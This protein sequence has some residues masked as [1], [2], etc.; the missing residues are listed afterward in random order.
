MVNHSF[1]LSLFALIGLS[2]LAYAATPVAVWDGN[3]NSLTCGNYTIDLQGNT[4]VTTTTTEGEAVITNALSITDDNLGVL[5]KKNSGSYDVITALVRCEGVDLTSSSDQA[6]FVANSPNDANNPVGVRLTASNTAVKGIWQNGKWDSVTGSA[7]TNTYTTLAFKYNRTDGTGKGTYLYA[8]TTNAEGVAS[9]SAIYSASELKRSAYYPNGVA[10][11]GLNT[12]SISELTAAKGMKISAIAIFEGDLSEAEMSSYKFLDDWLVATNVSGE[13]EWDKMTCSQ[14]WAEG[15]ATSN[16]VITLTGD[17]TI[18]LP[19]NFSANTIIF[20][21]NYNVT[22]KEASG[23]KTMSPISSLLGGK[24][25]T[26]EIPN[27]FSSTSTTFPAGITYRVCSGSSVSIGGDRKLSGELIVETNAT[28]TALSNDVPNYDNGFTLRVYGTLAHDNNRWTYKAGTLH[29]YGGCSVTG[30]GDN[31]GAVD[32]WN[33]IY[34]H[35]GDG[36]SDD[37]TTIKIDAPVRYSTSSATIN[38]DEGVTVTLAQAGKSGNDTSLLTKDGAGTLVFGAAQ[39]PLNGTVKVTAGT[40]VFDCESAISGKVNLASGTT[41]KV[42]KGTYNLSS[43]TLNGSVVVT[44]GTVTVPSTMAGTAKEETDGTIKVAVT[45]KEWADGV[46]IAS[47]KVTLRS[48]HTNLTFVYDGV[49]VEGTGMTLGNLLMDFVLPGT[50]TSQVFSYIYHPS[51]TDDNKWETTSNWK[52]NLRELKQSDGTIVTNYI[53]YTKS[54]AP[55]L[56]ESG[57]WAPILFDGVKVTASVVEGWEPQFGFYNHAD[58]TINTISKFQGDSQFIAVDE[59]SSLTIEALGS[60]SWD[61]TMNFYVAAPSGIVFS[62]T[63]DKKTSI[64]YYLGDKGSVAY[65]QGFSGT[66]TIKSVPIDLGDSTQYGRT[67]MKKYLIYG[68][69]TVTT[70]G[71]TVTG[72]TLAKTTAVAKTDEV[73]TYHFGSDETGLYI[74]WVAYASGATLT[75]STLSYPLPV[76]GTTQEF[77]YVYHP[78]GTDNKTWAT[79]TNWKTVQIVKDDTDS[80]ISTNYIAYTNSNAPGLSGS[81]TWDPILLDGVTV[82]A[83]QLEGWNARYGLYNGANVTVETQEKFQQD[84]ERTI[85]IF[86]AVDETSRFTV[87]AWG[88]SP[89]TGTIDFYVAA[90]SGIVFNVEYRKGD[91]VNYYIG[92]SGSV[93]YAKNVTAG[94][95]TLK[96]ATIELGDATLTGRQV[97]KKYLVI[98]SG[99]LTTSG[100]TVEGGTL[101]SSAVA[102]TDA[103]GTYY[104]GQDATG[105]Y[106]E[107]VAYAEKADGIF[108]TDTSG[109]IYEITGAFTKDANGAWVLDRAK[110]V[111]IT[112]SSGEETIFVIP[113]LATIEDDE[114]VGLVPFVLVESKPV[115]GVRTIPGLTYGLY[116]ATEL[117]A[118]WTNVKEEKANGRRVKF[119]DET[120]PDGKAFYQIRVRYVE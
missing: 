60:D 51:D 15:V 115:L 75:K 77:S 102:V 41:L 69:G 20:D 97:L 24:S 84:E 73:G 72:G 58:V 59:T 96:R 17:A 111:T 4:P 39:S 70:D 7:L 85:P 82:T 13:V 53:N 14:K 116:R 89:S 119:E 10:I 86:I 3:F 61:R 42:T 80:T 49:E 32:L 34:A 9:C 88:D 63:Y 48:D 45:A 40:L 5:V 90:P 21:G 81:G 112:D 93:Y 12:G 107:W 95:H 44:N 19:E 118:T 101:K 35:K 26:R 68:S 105:W 62:A 38:V 1:V 31:D 117:N 30:A 109:T 91:I 29:L 23:A 55:G 50:T 8:V 87:N 74:E 98:G 113:E 71:A 114:A 18:T 56:K 11:G 22:F 27:G 36:T 83:A 99:T 54:I 76:T 16:A 79:V 43:H 78:A 92:G 67:V 104:I 64:N 120:P 100:A 94:T 47:D 37:A 33:V 25:I 2:P 28:L 46:T 57:V 108:F 52:T 6:L 106:I 110:S 65:T 66:H 103:V